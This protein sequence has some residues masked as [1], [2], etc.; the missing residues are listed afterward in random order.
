MQ[1]KNK[2]ISFIS[3]FSIFFTICLNVNA[4]DLNIS[5]KEVTIDKKNNTILAKG[6]VEAIDSEGRIINS[7]SAFYQKSID[8]F[9]AQG[10]VQITDTKR[11]II[12]T[13]KAVYD[14]AKEVIITY[15]NSELILNPLTA[16]PGFNIENVY[17]LPGIPNIMK[18]M[19][20]IVYQF[21][22]QNN[23]I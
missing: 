14:Q 19:F 5:A 9:L 1:T 6:D 13:D 17:V 4:I 21:V 7:D 12:T 8:H 20:P 16:A 22:H 11:N 18:K 2:I 3:C 23:H 10:N 15:E